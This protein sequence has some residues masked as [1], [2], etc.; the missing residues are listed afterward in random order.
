MT[1][2]ALTHLDLTA[3]REAYASGGNVTETLRRQLGTGANTPA[4]IEAAYDLQAG[5]YI[6]WVRENRAQA[7]RYAAELASLLAPHLGAGGALLDIGT[8][9]LT[10]L[11]LLSAALPAVPER[12]LAFDISWS[13]LAAGLAFARAEMGAAF[14]RLSAFSAGIGAIPLA[15]GAVSVTTSSHALEPNGGSLAPL[16]A[17][18][19]RIT[20]DRLV[21]FE[22][23]WEHASEEGRRRMERLGYI[24]D[25]PGA[26]AALGGRVEQLTPIS[27][28]ANPLN[29]TVCFVISPPP[30]AA[31][32][33]GEGFTVPGTS[34]PLEPRAGG[35]WSRR[36]GLWFPVLGGIPVLRPEAGVLA[37]ALAG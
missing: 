31:A 20:R 7:E 26:V 27:A 23:S 24:R 37:S 4:I 28:V 12:I 32:L 34:L 18:L 5:S 3:A 21:L 9:E 16:L 25:L 35:L 8:G 13:R 29:P 22:P 30:R 14:P 2:A 10:T 33:G 19:F 11:S 17:E 6:A 36:T 15:D 1:D